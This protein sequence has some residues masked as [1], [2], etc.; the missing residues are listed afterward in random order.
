MSIE[1]AQTTSL[2]SGIRVVTE[3]V[4]SVRSVALGL[5]VR[6]GSRN[7]TLAQ[8]GVSHF[9]EHLLF[10]G[11]E[12]YSAIEISE[13]FDGLGAMVNAATGKETT[14]LHA[15]FLDEHTDE[16]FELLAEM[17]LGP[18]YPEIDSERD[19]VLE[20][21]AMYEDEP[22][23]RVHDIL[24]DAVF[25][26]H[27]LGRRVLGEA[28]VI[29]SIPVPDI[30]AYHRARY[31]GAN[32]VVGAAGHVDHGRIVALAER[33]VSP[34]A[35]DGEGA[36]GASVETEARFRFYPKDTEQYH[37]CF[38]APGIV[39]DDDRRYA[40][41][42]LDSIFGGST[43]S[44]LFREVREKRGLAY[45]VGSYNEQYTDTGL[46]AT[47]VGTRA[48]NVEEACA[49]IGAELAR[50]RS[51]PVSDEELSRGK[52][53][54][55]GRLVLSSESTAARMTRISR[56]TLFGLPIDSLD[57]MLAKVDAVTVEDLTELASELYG[58]ERL[59]AACIGSDEDSFRK[60]LAPVSESLAAA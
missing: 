50:L 24:A 47:Y 49:V 57:E 46:V 22:Q 18:T 41:A 55:K 12:R 54:V 58:A 16:V 38:G 42:V 45:A 3:E 23:D 35:G 7:E 44:R 14:H 29:A 39:R 28:E 30:S 33:L 34:A 8:A 27:P 20:E 4:P 6:T 25:G 17:L 19:V 31:T 9:L 60:A 32:L 59:S 43:S 21:I 26:Q 56:A 40:L 15:R 36:N 13:R 51:E 5:W 52:E 48:D 37:I 2:A 1:Q 10:K 53:S 11:T